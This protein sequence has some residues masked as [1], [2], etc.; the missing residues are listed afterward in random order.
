MNRIEFINSFNEYFKDLAAS[1]IRTLTFCEFDL[2]VKQYDN[3]QMHLD[4]LKD[5]FRDFFKP[6]SVDSPW[7]KSLKFQKEYDSYFEEDN[8]D[9]PICRFNMGINLHYLYDTIALNLN[10]S[11]ELVELYRI[12]DKD[13][14]TGLYGH[15]IAKNLF[16]INKQPGPL[17]DN[18][19]KEIFNEK[20]ETYKRYWSF[21][22]A[23]I[24]QAQE[25][26]ETSDLHTLL[27]N[28]NLCL[29]KFTVPQCFAIHGDKQ[30]I[31][32]KQ[33]MVSE[34]IYNLKPLKLKIK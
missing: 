8:H 3:P 32:Q 12:E 17:D 28:T 33:Y 27:S 20:N 26:M 24:N 2:D 22:F 29:K 13:G 9:A 31:F 14:N 30:S 1:K 16:D 10:K 7:F 21:S 34:D 15:S 5:I 6:L 19:L 4:A 25:W 18:K 23:N 11:V